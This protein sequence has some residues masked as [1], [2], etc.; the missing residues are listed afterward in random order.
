MRLAYYATPLH[1]ALVT[2]MT[3]TPANRASPCTEWSWRLKREDRLLLIDCFTVVGSEDLMDGM[4]VTPVESIFGY[5][6]IW[7]WG[8]F[9]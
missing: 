1:P 5:L 6:G 9:F 2:T 3:M 7:Y 8:T 4:D